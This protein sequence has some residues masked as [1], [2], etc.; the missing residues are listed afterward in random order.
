M[1]IKRINID[2]D[3]AAALFFA[4]AKC[5]PQLLDCSNWPEVA[6]YKPGAVL[7]AFHTGSELVLRYDVLEKC[8]AA[9]ET[10]FGGDVYKDSCVEFFID[11][12]G[13][14]ERYYNFESSCIGVMHF[15]YHE[16]Q[17]VKFPATREVYEQILAYSSVGYEPFDEV[18]AGERRHHCC[19]HHEEE[20]GG[21]HHCCHHHDENEGG[22]HHCCGGGRTPADPNNY[23]HITFIIPISAL[24]KDKFAS[25]DELKGARCNF[26]K[27]GDGLSKPHYLS[28]APVLTE[29]PNFHSPQFFGEVEFE[30]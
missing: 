27:C 14:G 30:K 5:E 21:E 10:N 17:G 9:R 20:E 13:K 25:W 24:Y 18:V 8:T 2:T 4:L 23:W 12:D 29:K 26:Y 1:I 7:R 6:P 19:C 11:P 28:W 22:E 15:G 16:L 3:D